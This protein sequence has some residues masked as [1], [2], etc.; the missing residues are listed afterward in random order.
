MNA[1]GSRAQDEGGEQAAVFT[2]TLVPG[3]S[4]LADVSA[5]IVHEIY[6]SCTSLPP[7]GAG[8]YLWHRE[9]PA[10]APGEDSSGLS[11]TL[12]VT[13]RVQDCVEDEWFMT[14]ILRAVTKQLPGLCVQVE[15]EDGEF[16]LIEAAHELPR[17]VRPENAT[18]RVWICNGDLHLVPLQYTSDVPHDEDLEE[19]I[20]IADAV[21]LVRDPNIATQAPLAVQESAFK[22]MEGY[23][24]AAAKHH[25][26]TLAVVPIN[27]A[28]IL[29][30]HP[31][32]IA[33]AV[34]A[35]TTRDVVSVR[36]AERMSLF[37]VEPEHGFVPAQN[38]VLIP[39]KMTQHLYAQLSHDR[40]FPPKAYGKRW[41]QSVEQYRL[42]MSD[43]A[44]K[45]SVSE[46]EAIFGRWCDTGAKLTAGLELAW[47]AKSARA[48]QTLSRG[49]V[50]PDEALIA[51]LTSLGY[52]EG[53]AP[54]SPR[55]KELAQEA[56][57]LTAVESNG[58]MPMSSRA[59]REKF[60]APPSARVQH[61]LLPMD[62]AQSRQA[63]DDEAWLSMI[64]EKLEELSQ[65]G[66]NAEDQTVDRL[67]SFMSKMNDF[68][69]GEG[70]V[71]GAMF[72]DD[73]FDDGDEQEDNSDL[74]EEL[75]DDERK[76]RMDALV[77]PVP[78]SEWGAANT[79]RD[80]E[81][82]KN[83]EGPQGP[84]HGAL[85][86]KEGERTQRLQGFSHRE[87]YEGNSDSDG[88]LEGDEQDPEE[89]R[90]DRRRWLELED[91][92]EEDDG[93]DMANEIAG[94]L[95][96]TRKELG[97]TDEQYSHIL[98]EREGRGGTLHV[99]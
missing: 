2:A 11:G 14:Y 6:N 77:Q 78:L 82:Q 72:Q 7:K 27:A 39:V 58:S 19:Y 1:Q 52:F 90:S 63:E 31:Q 8:G 81:S 38:V 22:R 13:M 9:A 71:E 93:V 20:S 51:S 17:W 60:E 67:G 56:H 79:A 55:W 64:P 40:F 87:H 86:K 48:A 68:L 94:F 54:N 85:T 3:A 34:H 50:G 76:R 84:T 70:D 61:S 33:D 80:P 12:K 23:P 45:P 99:Y 47:E 29:L 37:P 73:T 89:E 46:E 41:Q 25:H 83:T 88:S 74:E 32:M 66:A 57:A 24:K 59:L 98:K 42:Y 53:E 18:N 28:K 26:R 43:S 49:K 10:I 15:D 75:S 91:A 16:L 36:A 97:I 62:V 21:A 44:K 30:D 96:F 92:P 65:P 4:N 5:A 95:D 35:L 69:R